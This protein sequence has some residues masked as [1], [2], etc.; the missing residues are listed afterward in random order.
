MSPKLEEYR[1]GLYYRHGPEATETE[2]ESGEIVEDDNRGPLKP[3]R[4]G[5]RALAAFGDGRRMTAYEASR[6]ACGDYHAMRREARRLVDRGFLAKDG[7]LPNP[8]PRGRPHV[9]AFVITDA[10]RAELAR[11][12][13]L[14]Q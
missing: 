3:G 13:E 2:R 11:L 6:R 1:V 9:D 7:V 14:E 4:N 12:G 5:H 10:G 8:A